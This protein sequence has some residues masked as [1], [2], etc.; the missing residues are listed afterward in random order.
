[1]S[2]KEDKIRGRAMK[3]EIVDDFAK[4]GISPVG[5]ICETEEGKLQLLTYSPSG[6]VSFVSKKTNA[7]TISEPLGGR[8]FREIGTIRPKKKKAMIKRC[9]SCGRI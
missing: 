4:R 9:E 8:E 7:M 3:N 2:I 6:L 1:V 5:F